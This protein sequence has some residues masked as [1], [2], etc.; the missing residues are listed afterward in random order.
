MSNLRSGPNLRDRLLDQAMTLS[1]ANQMTLFRVAELCRDPLTDA[2]SI[3]IEAQRDEGFTAVLLRMANSAWSASSGRIGDL[4]TA[5]ARLGLHLVESLALATPGIR[6]AQSGSREFTQAQ[7]RMHRHAVRTGLGARALARSDQ[8]AEQALA[9]GL[10]HNIG[11]TV[12]AVLQP[13]V[14]AMLLDAASKGQ[15]LH[16]VEEE[17]IGFTHAELGGLLA[18]RWGFPLPLITVI[19]GHDDV[20]ATGMSAIVRV[21]DLLARE[22]GVGVEPP[23]PITMELAIEA[24]VDVDAA[25]ERLAPLFQA[26]ARHEAS[27]DDERASRDENFARVLDAAA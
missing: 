1:I 18:E 21:A 17:H 20:H 10:V 15:R 16:D 19:M 9:A 26:E 25:R 8:N 11:L 3:A 27:D 6:L 12:L 13:V 4:P 14:F 22:A 24:G 7:R 5:V 2:R 23:E